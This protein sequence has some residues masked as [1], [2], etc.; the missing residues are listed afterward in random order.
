MFC[1]GLL[2]ITTLPFSQVILMCFSFI[3]EIEKYV[4]EQGVFF[5]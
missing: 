4:L 2:T 1:K 5:K 3:K